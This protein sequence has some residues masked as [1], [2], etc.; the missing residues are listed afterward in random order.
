MSI[1]FVSQVLSLKWLY[2]VPGQDFEKIPPHF[3]S[4][5]ITNLVHSLNGSTQQREFIALC[6]IDRN[7][8]LI[9]NQVSN[10]FSL[11]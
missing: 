5:S 4:P 1:T 11:F 3:L 10:N 9:V 6:L 2:A 8:F 7:S